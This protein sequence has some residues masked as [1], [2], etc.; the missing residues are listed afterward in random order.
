MEIWGQIS[1]YTSY[2]EKRSVIIKKYNLY[3]FY[4]EWHD[5]RQYF[6]PWLL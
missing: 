4:K 1:T 3:P 6:H 5:K 2:M